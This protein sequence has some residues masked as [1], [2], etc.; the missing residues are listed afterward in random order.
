[1]ARIMLGGK[2]GKDIMFV[3]NTRFMPAA[4]SKVVRDY[5]GRWNTLRDI[6][7]Y[8]KLLDELGEARAQRQFPDTDWEALDAHYRAHMLRFSLV[9]KGE[10]VDGRIMFACGCPSG[11]P[12]KP[13]LTLL[14]SWCEPG[15]TLRDSFDLWRLDKLLR[16]ANAQI[17]YTPSFT[18]TLKSFAATGVSFEESLS[19]FRQVQAYHDPRFL[20]PELASILAPYIDRVHTLRD[21]LEL[22]A[23]VAQLREAGGEV[24]VDRTVDSVV[25]HARILAD[26]T[27]LLVAGKVNGN[28]PERAT[29]AAHSSSASQ[30]DSLITTSNLY[31]FQRE[32]VAF[33]VTNRRALLADDMG[34]GKTIQA[35]A[36]AAY[37]KHTQ[38]LKRALV[39]CPASL[40]Y[41]WQAEI[42]KFTRERVEVIAG[43]PAEREAIYRAAASEGGFISPE[44][45]PFFYIVNYEL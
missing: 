3:G 16:R 6:T 5:F 25:A 33:L 39:I 34:L 43:E 9:F 40:K 45:K 22:E 42:R 13:L 36:A 26:Q 1:M 31:P 4:V 29:P 8:P 20:Q 28:I 12:A 30:L 2:Y 17:K 38:G 7:R 41:Q 44:D 37:L 35:I 14:Q 19:F 23:V 21:P 32:G 11:A 15:G 10:V 24:R 27:D 18:D